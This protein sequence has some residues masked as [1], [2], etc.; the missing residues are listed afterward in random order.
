MFLFILRSGYSTKASNF[1]TLFFLFL[2]AELHITMATKKWQKSYFDVLGLCCSSEVPL[3]EKILKPLDGVKEIS[4]I[5][6]SRT[7]IVVHDN[8]LISQIQ[9][10]NIPK[11]LLCIN[12]VFSHSPTIVQKNG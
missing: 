6:P 8:L 1:L 10:G 7:L 11:S 4:V 3:I 9:I 5:V 2:F 12:M